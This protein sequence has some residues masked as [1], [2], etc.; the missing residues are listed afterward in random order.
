[1]R[2]I[3]DFAKCRIKMCKRYFFSANAISKSANAISKSANAISKSANAI[4]KSANAILKCANAILK[5]ANAI[6][7]FKSCGSHAWVNPFIVEL[8]AFF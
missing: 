7:G 2:Q 4:S 8:T 1:M 3:A 5:C 6:C